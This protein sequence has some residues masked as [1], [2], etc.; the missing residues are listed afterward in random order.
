MCIVAVT[1]RTIILNSEYTRDM[2]GIKLHPSVPAL[3][4]AQRHHVFL[5][6]IIYTNI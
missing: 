1:Q 5:N 6:G 3:D 2:T 4:C